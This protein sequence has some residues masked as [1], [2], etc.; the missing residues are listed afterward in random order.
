MVKEN[1]ILIGGGGHCRS[2]IDVIESEDKYN[3]LGIVD[4]NT[5]GTVMGYPVLGKDE[6][7]SSL[8][9]V[10]NNFVITVGQINSSDLR[11][12]LYTK[13]KKLGGVFPVIVSPLAYVARTA[14]IQEG[15]VILHHVL[16]NSN[17]KIGINNIINTGALIEHDTVVGS[18]N[19]ISTKVVINGGCEVKDNTF[20]G[21]GTIVNQEVKIESKIVIGSG[22]LIRNSL[23]KEGL[24]SGSPIKLIK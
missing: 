18:Y 14:L 19:H 3:I 8:V 9:K 23:M 6:V 4:A 12:K 1:I 17:V 20:I 5:T 21:S 13:I 10:G 24:Y 2:V 22:S 15:T 11:V 16:I 7:I